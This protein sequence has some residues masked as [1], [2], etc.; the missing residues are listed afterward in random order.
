MYPLKVSIKKKEKMLSSESNE[1]NESCILYSYSKKHCGNF[2]TKLTGLISDLAGLVCSYMSV[3]E[4]LHN[5]LLLIKDPMTDPALAQ[6]ILDTFPAQIYFQGDFLWNVGDL[7]K[8]FFRK[9]SLE[10]CFRINS[11]KITRISMC[12]WYFSKKVAFY[13]DARNVIFLNYDEFL[14]CLCDSGFEKSVA[15]LIAEA[16]TYLIFK[17]NTV[18][19][20]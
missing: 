9:N 8:I 2:L 3:S 5:I 1:S 19:W 13:D 6:F 20:L 16:V 12:E 10:D 4:A 14:T 17:K 15:D 18:K 7:F 11:Q